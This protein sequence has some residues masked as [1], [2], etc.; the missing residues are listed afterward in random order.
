MNLG[1]A[2]SIYRAERN[3]RLASRR[4]ERSASEREALHAAAEALDQLAS[5]IARYLTSRLG[6]PTVSA[7]SEA[8]YWARSG[9]GS[10]RL[11]RHDNIPHEID[12]SYNPDKYS[13]WGIVAQLV[14]AAN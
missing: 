13:G 5:E 1:A 8:L 9:K 14:E 11:A 4:V 2:L 12:I 7:K 3:T 6:A 10:V